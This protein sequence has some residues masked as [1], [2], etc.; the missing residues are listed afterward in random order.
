MFFKILYY[1]FPN[2]IINIQTILNIV[3]IILLLQ[4]L[5]SFK[6]L[7]SKINNLLSFF[8]INNTINTPNNNNQT[9]LINYFKNLIQIG[10]DIYKKNCKEKKNNKKDSKA[11]FF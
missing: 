9:E 6:L 4:V 2:S 11:N 10:Q 7:F 5:N 3:L 1:I 8:K